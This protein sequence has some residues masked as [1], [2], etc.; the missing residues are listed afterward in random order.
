MK[1]RCASACRPQKF[2][3]VLAL[4]SSFVSAA[5]AW[6][7]TIAAAPRRV[8]LQVGDGTFGTSGT[9]NRV[10]VT[11]PT[12]QVNAGAGQAMTSDSTQSRSPYDNYLVCSP[13]AQ[14]F[15]AASYQRSSSS[16]GPATALLQVTSQP[17]LV[18]A[19]GDTI[20]FS[21]ISW[22]TSSL[23]TADTTPNV[24]PPGTF[25][26]ATQTLATVQANRLIEN[27]HTF[28]YANTAARAA[29]IYNG[30][31]VYTITTP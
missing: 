27:C 22:S 7:L 9:V 16:N 4:L 5:Q 20:A 18:N 13:P 31:V 8:Y 14:I 23:G 26:G 17:N 28:S 29:G 15:V 6:T 3:L 1:L 24:I 2:L 11:V 21:Q 30:Q 10:S 12:T 19:T 25:N